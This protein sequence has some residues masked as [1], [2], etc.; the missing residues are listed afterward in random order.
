MKWWDKEV[1]LALFGLLGIIVSAAKEIVLSENDKKKAL[2][3]G[4]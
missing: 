4:R 3:S 2:G 1:T